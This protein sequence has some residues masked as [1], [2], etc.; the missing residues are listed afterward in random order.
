VLSNLGLEPVILHEQPDRRRTIIE[1]FYDYSDVGF[2]VVLLSPDD[3]GYVATADPETAQP[4]A[5]QNVILGLG[6]FLANSAATRTVNPSPRFSFKAFCAQ[7]HI[8]LS[9]LIA[10]DYAIIINSER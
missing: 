7:R 5:P 10:V 2:A 9:L 1:K 3:R 8:H 6:F 4:Q